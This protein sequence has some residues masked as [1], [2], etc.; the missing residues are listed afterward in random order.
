MS[1]K[2]VDIAKNLLISV[3]VLLLTCFTAS[4]AQPEATVKSEQLV[5]DV[6]AA[7]DAS[8]FVYNSKGR[9]DPFKPLVQKTHEIISKASGRS[10]KIK[11]PLERFELSHYRLVAM[12][13]VKGNPRAM[14]K[15]PDGKGY[16]VKIG[17]YIGLN[18]GLVKMIQTKIVETDISGMRIEKSPD[19]IVIEEVGVDTLTGKEVRENH[20]IVM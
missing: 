12:M 16:T 3:S 6:V 14:V 8:V 13:V 11:G 5:Q 2:S 7:D 20:Y 10:D 19:R 18:D 9:R 4:A 17:E 1:M 15:G